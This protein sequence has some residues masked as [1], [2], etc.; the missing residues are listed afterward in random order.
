MDEDDPV[1][2]QIMI[3]REPPEPGTG[4][5]RRWSLNLVVDGQAHPI[6]L[7]VTADDAQAAAEWFARCWAGG[8]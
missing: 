6:G 7:P 5:A 2:A 8:R 3:Q 1:L 4:Q